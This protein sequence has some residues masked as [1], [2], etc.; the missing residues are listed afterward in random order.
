MSDQQL[1]DECVTLFLAGHET[2]SIALAN[3]LYLLSLHPE[4][5]ADQ[6]GQVLRFGSDPIAALEPYRSL[7]A[8]GKLNARKALERSD[9]SFQDL[10]LFDGI[11][12]FNN[13]VNHLAAD[14]CQYR[15]I[16]VR[17]NG[18]G[19][20]VSSED[21]RCFRQRRLDWQRRRRGLAYDI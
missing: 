9:P 13:D 8:A 7:F 16:S 19:C 18:G 1:R 21:V 11:P 10:A 5:S 3:T 15:R 14:S 20:L 6:L 4:L 12:F 17:Q 2:T